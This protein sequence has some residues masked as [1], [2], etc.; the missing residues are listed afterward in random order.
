[1]KAIKILV[2]F[3]LVLLSF[4]SCKE[5]TDLSTKV[6]ADATGIGKIDLPALKNKALSWDVVYNYLFSED[7]GKEQLDWALDIDR[8]SYFYTSNNNLTLLV[9]ITDSKKFKKAIT[10][11]YSASTSAENGYEYLQENGIFIGWEKDWVAISNTIKFL[12]PVENSSGTLLSRL[13]QTHDVVFSYAGNDITKKDV[14]ADL[15]LD[16]N[17]GEIELLVK[18]DSAL[19]TVSKEA[20]GWKKTITKLDTDYEAYGSFLNKDQDALFLLNETLPYLQECGLLYSEQLAVLTPFL[21]GES[22][23]GL[24]KKEVRPQIAGAQLVVGVTTKDA[25]FA[26]TDSSWVKDK[27]TGFYADAEGFQ[28]VKYV[29]GFLILSNRNLEQSNFKNTNSLAELSVNKNVLKGDYLS[30]VEMRFGNKLVSNF[31]VESVYFNAKEGPENSLEA[32]LK[33]IF[34]EKEKNTVLSIMDFVGVIQNEEEI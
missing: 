29:D 23:L 6:P 13:S 17:D 5:R 4:F 33:I 32:S 8:P 22:Q 1:M 16:F 20:L 3:C 26:I 2:S 24:E 18:G 21:T 10:S 31:P 14:V 28:F 7:N 27:E 11:T 12:E 30:F 19:R 25:L 15:S 34:K 9:P